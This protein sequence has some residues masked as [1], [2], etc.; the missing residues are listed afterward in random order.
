MR[1]IGAAA[2]AFVLALTFIV[3]VS[4]VKTTIDASG[5]P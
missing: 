3:S 2:I 4:L 5:W 1:L